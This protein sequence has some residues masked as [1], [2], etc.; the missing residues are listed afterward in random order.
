MLLVATLVAAGY[1]LNSVGH[2]ADW[3]VA[4]I[5]DQQ[6]A[7]TDLENLIGDEI[8]RY[9]GSFEAIGELFDELESRKARHPLRKRDDS[10]ALLPRIGQIAGVADAQHLSRLIGLSAERFRSKKKTLNAMDFDDLLLGTR[11]LLKHHTAIRQRYKTHFQALLIDEFQD[12]DEVQAEII[13]LLAEDPET[14]GRFAPRKL[15]IVGDPKQSIYRFRRARV[16]VFFRMV[17]RILA[18]GGVI[19]HLQDNYRSA[20]PIAEFAN[21]LSQMMMDGR[22]K[23]DIRNETVDLS[24]RIG[25]K[26]A[27]EVKEP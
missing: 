22:G 23:A 16:T 11:D 2:N 1:W 10:R 26:E 4:R 25:F 14:A 5:Q 12:T 7:A 9:G 21:R 27:E 15:M 6:N 20:P 13:S 24:Y 8:R 3:L 19:E 17:Q 18:E